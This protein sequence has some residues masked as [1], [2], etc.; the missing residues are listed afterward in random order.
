MT[1]NASGKLSL[2]GATQGESVDL[3][4]SLSSNSSNSMVSADNKILTGKSTGPWVFPVDWRGKHWYNEVITDSV[5]G[6]TN[7][8]TSFTIS[9][10]GGRPSTSFTLTY[11]STTTLLLTTFNGS[12][13]SSGNYTSVAYTYTTAG[14]YSFSFNFT[15]SRNSRTHYVTINNPPL[16]LSWNPT[17]ITDNI[18]SGPYN[19]DD[20]S[21]LTAASNNA[22]TQT[23]TIQETSRPSSWSVSINSSSG[24]FAS[25]T[26]SMGS[27]STST[28]DFKIFPPQGTAAGT[29]TG[30]FA[31]VYNNST[32]ILSLPWSITITVNEV[33][34]SSGG[35]YNATAGTYVAPPNTSITIFV[36]NA[37]A[38]D[39]VTYTGLN[40]ISLDSS[41]KYTLA[42]IN[43]ASAGLYTY[44][45]NF[46]STGHS[47][48]TSFFIYN[49]LITVNGVG[50]LSNGSTV[51][52]YTTDS[53]TIAITGGIPGSGYSFSRTGTSAT[54][55]TGTLDSSGSY[56]YTNQS[57]P[58]AGTYNYTIN[59]N[60]T[61]GSGATRTFTIVSRVNTID[62]QC[63]VIG[64]G[65]AGGSSPGANDEGAGGGGGGGLVVGNLLSTT[66]GSTG[67]TPV[68]VLVGAGGPASPGQ[69]QGG[70]KTGNGGASYVY[71]YSD[72][73]FI[74][75]DGGGGGAAAGNGDAGGCGGGGSGA[76]SPGYGGTGGGTNFGLTELGSNGGDSDHYGGG[77]GGGGTS[78]VGGHGIRSGRSAAN[79][80]G[81]GGS[82]A[83]YA[84]TTTIGT[85]TFNLGGGGG[86]GGSTNPG[87]GGNENA[88]AGGGN[89]G[90]FNGLV[91]NNTNS[92]AG[93]SGTS[94]TGCGGGGSSAGAYFGSYSG[95][96]GGSG[97]VVI[98]YTASAPLFSGG[99]VYT[100]A[101][102][103][104]GSI[105]HVYINSYYLTAL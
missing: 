12:L 82:G 10:S 96:N 55:G 61:G 31:A 78:G 91:G 102:I 87:A 85:L 67:S 89:S 5:S 28:V 40:T 69:D 41:G 38:Y 3:E 2:G 51:T 95:G 45:F 66:I 37:V 16:S 23:V 76:G 49:E 86:G 63:Y 60:G 50:L 100:G 80:G 14:T 90:S 88:G 79:V 59:F 48:S 30:S 18:F 56:T 6:S 8:Y 94:S 99:A 47:R 98:I 54:S 57:L 34:Y 104:A 26:V 71:R 22:L 7:I 46:A 35:T 33:V 53:I 75:A 25:T 81:T 74:Y 84:I 77:G 36:T 17:S 42:N 105:F 62:L 19:A 20:I 15:G 43:T 73:K 39:S 64:G 101:G 9:V 24:S 58:Q 29:Y 72:Q 70:S 4:I 92:Y 103:N 27:G 32:S 1:L 65:A 21:V 68:Y 83:Y 52:V 93:G 13:D 11:Y 44:N 97:I